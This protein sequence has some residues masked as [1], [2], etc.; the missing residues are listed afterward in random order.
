MIPSVP[1]H[2]L[3]AA[4][5]YLRDAPGTDFALMLALWRTGRPAQRDVALQ[6][7]DDN[8]RRALPTP[9]AHKA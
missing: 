3:D 6:M 7:A 5:A 2:N 1:T 9:P 4:L 8:R